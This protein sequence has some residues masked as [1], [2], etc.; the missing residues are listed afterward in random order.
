MSSEE[1]T[2]SFTRTRGTIESLMA[3]D[4]ILESHANSWPV[5]LPGIIPELLQYWME[6]LA[7]R[8]DELDIEMPWSEKH[9][10]MV[11]ALLLAVPSLIHPIESPS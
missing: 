9:E 2:V 6:A 10:A 7:T 1:V 3:L 8:L 11:D 4:A 5:G